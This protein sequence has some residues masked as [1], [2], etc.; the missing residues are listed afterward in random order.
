MTKK[1]DLGRWST[2]RE[3][4]MKSFS[5][6]TVKGIAVRRGE[7]VHAFVNRCTHMGGPLTWHENRFE[8]AW[9]GACFTEEGLACSGEA[10][11]GSMLTSIPVERVD[12]ALYAT[13]T[14]PE[15]PFSF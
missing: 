14:L 6:A 5:F 1:I 4:E 10:P 8:C 11:E 7:R 2:W 12:D 3:N 13:V 15:D 9:H